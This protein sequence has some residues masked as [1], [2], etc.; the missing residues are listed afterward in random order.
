[1]LAM[2]DLCVDH[3][4]SSNDALP[5]SILILRRTVNSRLG[6]LLD[7]FSATFV[8]QIALKA[9]G[10]SHYAALDHIGKH[11]NSSA[12]SYPEFSHG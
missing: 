11:I 5:L 1:M 9:K 12:T 10:S 7:G 4:G 2:R 6:F 8:P 3:Q